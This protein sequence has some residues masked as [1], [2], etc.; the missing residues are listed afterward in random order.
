MFFPIN[1]F[2]WYLIY[3]LKPIVINSF[4]F[5]D[6]S[7]KSNEQFWSKK[8]WVKCKKYIELTTNYIYLF[9][10]LHMSKFVYLIG[11]LAC[12]YDKCCLYLF[13]LLL[14][15]IGVV[16]SRFVQHITIYASSTLVSVILLL[17]MIYQIQYIQQV[18]NENLNVTCEVNILIFNLSI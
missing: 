10:E 14:I 1:S 8:T 15:I 7:H 9:L 4:N 16:G 2:F 6:V 12:V 3:W 5:L 18:Y 11:M 17:R 13:F